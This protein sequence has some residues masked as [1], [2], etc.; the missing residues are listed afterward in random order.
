MFRFTTVHVENIAS[1]K[2]IVLNGIIMFR[3]ISQ[4]GGNSFLIPNHNSLNNIFYMKHKLAAEL[5]LKNQT[6][7]CNTRQ[8]HTNLL[9]M[10][11]GRM[12][13]NYWKPLFCVI[14]KLCFCECRKLYVQWRPCSLYGQSS[15]IWIK[16]FQEA[17]AG[18]EPGV[19]MRSVSSPATLHRWVPP[20]TSQ[21]H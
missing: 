4:M 8:G 18:L 1:C 19:S 15:Q 21:I 16:L 2:Y 13:E 20:G 5:F 6:L 10:C 14:N 7:S 9:L 17:C 3:V 11:W 12:V